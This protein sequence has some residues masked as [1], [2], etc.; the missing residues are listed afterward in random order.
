MSKLDKPA[1]IFRPSAKSLN[2]SP[3]DEDTEGH[4]KTLGASSA[5]TMGASSAKTM[6][7]SSAKT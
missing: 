6:G 2:V 5:K 4:A 7:A 1:K 3:V